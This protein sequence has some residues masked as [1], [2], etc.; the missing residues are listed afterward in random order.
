MKWRIIL[1]LFA[2]STFSSC[3]FTFHPLYSDDVL[4]DVPGLEGQFIDKIRFFGFETS[5]STIWT[6]TREEKGVYDLEIVDGEAS[7]GMEV[8][9]VKLGGEFFLDFKVDEV[10]TEDIPDFVLF[11]LVPMHSFAKIR[12]QE[13]ELQLWFI[14]AEWAQDNL[15]KHR[16]RIDHERRVDEDGETELILLTADTEH[17]QKFAEKYARYDEA[18]DDP[19]I[20]DRLIAH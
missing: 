5:D 14:D 6:F 1:G 13:A 10:E 3:I 9:A 8:H 18:F 4:V 7:G 2:L 16:I 19:E 15:E 17:L 12:V 20:L 11:H